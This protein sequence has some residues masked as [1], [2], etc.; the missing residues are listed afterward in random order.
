MTNVQREFHTPDDFDE[1]RELGPSAEAVAIVEEFDDHV[2]DET[3]RG[4]AHFDLGGNRSD[5]NVGVSM[6][7]VNRENKGMAQKAVDALLNAGFRFT[8]RST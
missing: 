7:R 3:L 2:N 4:Y 5:G 6:D 1:P 8:G